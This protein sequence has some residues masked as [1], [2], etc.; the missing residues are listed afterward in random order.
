MKGK[1]IIEWLT[2]FVFLTIGCQSTVKQNGAV[3]VTVEPELKLTWEFLENNYQQKSQNLSHLTLKNVGNATLANSGWA[4]YFNWCRGLIPE[5][6]PG[7]LTGKHLNGDF[8]QIAPTKD[9]PQLAPGDSII[10]PV[11]GTH[12]Q[13]NATDAPSG[14]YI[15]FSE[16]SDKPLIQQ[17]ALS[18]KPV[19][20]ERAFIKEGDWI[21]YETVSYTHLTLPTKRIV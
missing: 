18:V 15:V 4:I 6:L 5:Q 1:Q 2:V 7:M 12:W 3:A 14:I 8:Y 16:E 21:R 13:M 17:L 9:F 19:L 10:I 20:K 11:V